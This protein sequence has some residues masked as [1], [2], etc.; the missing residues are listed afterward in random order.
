MELQYPGAILMSDGG[1]VP[2][3]HCNDGRTGG[4]SG[5]SQ[6][7]FFA[8]TQ[9]RQDPGGEHRGNTGGTQSFKRQQPLEFVKRRVV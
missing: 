9:P 4:G 1:T 6:E 7:V 8:S 2:Y 3:N 5:V